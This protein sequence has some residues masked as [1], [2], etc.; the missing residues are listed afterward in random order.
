MVKLEPKKDNRIRKL[1]PIDD[2]ELFYYELA[3]EKQWLDVFY[4]EEIFWVSMETAA[5]ILK[6][7]EDS[8]SLLIENNCDSK[9][10]LKSFGCIKHGEDAVSQVIM[11][12]IEYLISVGCNVDLAEATRLN[13]WKA[14]QERELLKRMGSS[15]FIYGDA[16]HLVFGEVIKSKQYSDY[17]KAPVLSLVAFNIEIML[18]S[19]IMLQNGEK[20]TGH[21]LSKLFKK[22]PEETRTKFYQKFNERGYD[23]KATNS[24]IKKTNKAFV[25]FRY[26]YENNELAISE[27]IEEFLKTF[28]EIA[29][30]INL[31]AEDYNQ[32]NEV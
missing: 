29:H 11:C 15:A 1:D 14:E 30:E 24:M 25:D 13:R 27:E 31:D 12:N 22:L 28:W 9:K 4:M 26:K 3:T 2:Y 5:A 7:P 21:E 16:Y 17:T 23:N 20:E 32:K 8:V 6:C 19:I 10:A 18:K